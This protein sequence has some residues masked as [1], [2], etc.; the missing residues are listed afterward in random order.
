MDTKVLKA[1]PASIKAAAELIRAGEVVGF[2]TETVYGLGA[3]ALNAGAVRKIFEAKG[4]PGDNPLIVHIA[5]IGAIDRLIEGALPESARRLAQAYWPGPL[6]MIL[7]KSKLIPKEVSA[8]LETVGIRMPSHPV[9]RALIAQA[10]TPI[11]APS[12]NLS[13]RPSPT[14]ASH[15]FSDMAGRIALILDGGACAVG[16]ESTVLDVLCDPVRILRPGGV[17]AE[18]IAQVLGRVTVDESVMRPLGK[19]EV[20]RSPGMKYKHYAPRGHLTI[21]R[22]AGAPEAI[23]RMYDAALG[24]GE[25]PLI[26]GLDAH[27][28]GYGARAVLALGDG[29]QEAAARLFSALREADELGAT[30]IFSEAVAQA[31]VGLAVMNRMG[32]AAAFDVVEVG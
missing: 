21:V 20:A 28:G 3:D 10:G 29:A 4:R 31:G 26:L 14:Q 27:I 11:A 19:G 15:V 8:G 30:R 1:E 16:V 25:T 24:Q 6:T 18:M 2:P 22:G 12:A 5:D 7:P 13:G 17:T 23:A 9:A 32:R